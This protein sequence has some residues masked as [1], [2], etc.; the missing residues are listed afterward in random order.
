MRARRGYIDGPFGQLH[1]VE[2]GQGP[3]VVLVHMAGFNAVQYSRALPHFAVAG[4]RALAIDL[5]GFGGSETPPRPPSIFDYATSV[6]ALM[7]E[8]EL[9]AVTIVGSH[10]GAEVA[11]EVAVTRPDAI[12][13]VVLVGPLATSPEDRAVGQRQADIE[14]AVTPRSD[15]AH[16]TEMWE[17]TARFFPGMTDVPAFQ[18][19]ITS[20]LDAAEHNWYGHNAVFTYDHLASL[21]R[22]VQPTLILTNTGD[23]AHPF[24]ARTHE[25]FPSFAYRAL[26]GGTALIVDEKPG[27]WT[28][29]VID[30]IRSSTME[31]GRM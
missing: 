28:T 6:A 5:P 1:Y 21:E 15:G 30:F 19:L 10:L 23:I 4:Y 29:A 20:Q 16:V 7:D 13:R 9:P 27:E 26:D 12:D 31:N 8:L 2:Q 3:P 17:Y 22:Q 25:L 14:R 18:R 24:S 11:T